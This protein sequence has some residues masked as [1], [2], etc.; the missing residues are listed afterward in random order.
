MFDD[1]GHVCMMFMGMGIYDGHGMDMYNEYVYVFLIGAMVNV[2][3]SRCDGFILLYYNKIKQ[4]IK[5]QI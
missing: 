5:T 1:H 4:A 2:M 3:V